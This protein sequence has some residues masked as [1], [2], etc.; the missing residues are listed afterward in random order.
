MSAGHEL[1]K[2]P[3]TVSLTSGKGGVGKTSLAVNLAVAL[4][5]NGKR[6]LIVDGDLGLANVDVLLRIHVERNLRDVIENGDDPLD[7]IVP[8]EPNL[9]VLPASSGVPEMLNLGQREQSL[10]E[11][12]LRKISSQYDIVLV[13][14]AAGIGQS[15]LWLNH[16]ADHPIIVV[17]PDPTS[18]TDA[19]A[20]IKVMAREYERDSFHVVVNGLSSPK[21]GEEVFTTLKGV[22]AKFLQVKLLHLGSVPLDS[23]V[24]KAVRRQVPFLKT[25]PDSKAARAILELSARIEKLPPG[26]Q[27]G[28]LNPAS[29]SQPKRLAVSERG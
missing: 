9:S 12:L 10:L 23:E 3:V 26:G 13:D 15:V 2:R 21:E 8:I 17:T 4:S 19:Y 27:R 1:L 6:V 18:M 28:A 7:T 14:T 11:S 24:A 22:A 5:R 29:S 20:L 16:F 25:S